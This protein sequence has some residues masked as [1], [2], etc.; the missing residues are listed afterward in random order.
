MRVKRSVEDERMKREERETA[1]A[2]IVM[3]CT[4]DGKAVTARLVEAIAMMIE[5]M[6]VATMTSGDTLC[7]TT[8]NLGG[9]AMTMGRVTGIV[10]TNGERTGIAMMMCA[11]PDLTMMAQKGDT[12]TTNK[13]RHS[14]IADETISMTTGTIDETTSTTSMADATITDRVANATGQGRELL[15]SIMP[16]ATAYPPVHVRLAHAL[17]RHTREMRRKR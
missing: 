14:M 15:T 10:M 5:E 12:V 8:T 13:G 9:I 16:P 3:M 4:K 7:G 11:L 2:G 1:A 17:L 6:H